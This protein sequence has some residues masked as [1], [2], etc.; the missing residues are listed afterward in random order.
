MIFACTVPCKTQPH[1]RSV[2]VVDVD[3]SSGSVTVIGP[4]RSVASLPGSTLKPFL[5]STALRLGIAHVQTKI[6]CSGRLQLG[7]RNLACA[8]PSSLRV[9]DAREAL[10]YSCNSYFAKL[11]EQMPPSAL[12]DGLR[13][14]GI[15]VDTAPSD[16]QQRALEA[17]GLERIRVTPLQ[18][19]QA[20][21]ILAREWNRQGTGADA[22]RDGL[23]DSVT[24]GMANAAKTP[25]LKLAGKTG[26][27]HDPAPRRQHGWFA[28]M[29]FGGPSSSHVSRVVVL[30]VPGGSGADAAAA[31]HVFLQGRNR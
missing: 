14:Y 2:T 15:A 16:P 4:Y 21:V 18:L 30:Y 29:V 3:L 24:Y 31:A 25:L 7:G 9:L 22:V 17:L 13:H 26:T 11:A 8:H 28:G 23:L 5:L 10:A 27:A 1:H 19:A 20:Y 12:V 6:D